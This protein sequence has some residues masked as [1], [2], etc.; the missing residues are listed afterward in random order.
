MSMRKITSLT[1]FVSFFVVTTTSVVLFVVPHGRVAYWA[2]WRLWGL[3]KDQ[4][5]GIHINTGL[6]FLVSLLLHIYYNWKSIVRY[7]KDKAEKL[8]VFT[9]DFNVALLVVVLCVAGTFAEVPPFSTIMNINESIKVA[10]AGKYGE[11]PYGHAELSS[12]KSLSMK[13]GFDSKTAVEKI[14]ESGYKVE[15]E[16]QTLLQIALDNETTPQTIYLA[17]E[18]SQKK[19]PVVSGG[20]EQLPGSPPPGTGNLTLADFCAK[21]GLNKNAV[22]AMFMDDGI[23]AKEEMTIREIAK[24]NQASPFDIYERI[25]SMGR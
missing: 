10:S 4:W 15:G 22:L 1:A 18:P 16:E 20:A 14:K 13:M 2:D 21:Y 17:M 6:L 7:L 5:G 8:T 19:P 23:S 3:S 12:V 9:A 25:R 24:A 11:P